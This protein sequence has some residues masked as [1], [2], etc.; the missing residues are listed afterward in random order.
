MKQFRCK[1]CI[2]FYCLDLKKGICIENDRI[3]NET[4][5]IYFACNYTNEEGTKCEQCLDGYE[6]GEEGYCIDVERC[7]ERENGDREGKCAETTPATQLHHSRKKEKLFRN[8]LLLLGWNM[9]TA[10]PPYRDN[11]W[12]ICEF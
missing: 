10:F 4:Y 6:V 3:E 7:I 2:E 1:E 8:H 5:K 11:K 12:W 9:R